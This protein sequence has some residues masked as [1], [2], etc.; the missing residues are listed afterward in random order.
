MKMPNIC[1]M[2]L[3]AQ[4]ADLC[5][6]MFSTEAMTLK[7]MMKLTLTSNSLLTQ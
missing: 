6:K 2:R 7:L 4:F 3:S 5:H 1:P